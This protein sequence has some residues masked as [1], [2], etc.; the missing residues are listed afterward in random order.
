MPRT[1][2]RMAVLPFASTSSLPT[3]TLPAY[4]PATTSIVGAICRHGPH[5]SAKKSTRTGTSA[6]STSWSNVASEKFNVL[7]PVISSPDLSLNIRIPRAPKD[8]PPQQPPVKRRI[9]RRR[10]FPRKILAHAAPHHLLPSLAI[11]KGSPGGPTRFHNRLPGESPEL[12]SRAP[13]DA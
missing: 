2:Y 12:D 10:R 1:L 8:S 6:R 9:G 5:H 7:T 4:S 13:L 11:R 3:F